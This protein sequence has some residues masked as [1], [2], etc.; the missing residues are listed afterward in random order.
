[1]PERFRR[2]TAESSVATERPAAGEREG[3]PPGYRMRADAHYVE[4]LTAR[5]P[6]VTVRHIAVEEIDAP[7]IDLATVEPLT[8]SIAAHGVLQPLLVR[9]DDSRFRVIA[10]KKRLG[11]A[12]AAGLSTVPCLIHQAD[13]AAAE[14]LAQAENTRGGAPDVG[15]GAGGFPGVR[16]ILDRLAGDLDG[17]ESAASLLAGRSR[18]ASRR[19]TT[20][21]I[22][23]EAWRA[24]WLLRAAGISDRP[25]PGEPQLAVLGTILERVRQNFLP[26]SR[27]SGVDIQVCV[28]DWNVSADVDEESLAIG[29]AGAII[30]T[31]GF[32]EEVPGSVITLIASGTAG[33]PVSLDVAQDAAAVPAE[34]AGRL[35]D[36]A[37]TDRPGGW[38]ALVGALT[39]RTVAE[40][41][42]GDATFVARERRGSTLRLTLDPAR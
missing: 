29:L 37:W 13:E 34:A 22:R 39:A 1:M 40:Q 7:P 27:M 41:H 4:Q 38:P 31:L 32:V 6:D 21:M 28:P 30:A 14:L 17:I 23:A 5:S 3:L 2:D 15:A 19:A 9:R 33:G 26:E 8:R 16:A 25:D 18:P 11:A 20:D 42:G 24:S 10:G 12:R 35:F 36:P